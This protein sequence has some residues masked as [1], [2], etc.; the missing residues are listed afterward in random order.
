MFC[1]NKKK[2]LV[3]FIILIGIVLYSFTQITTLPTEK[4]NK[5]YIK[6]FNDVKYQLNILSE[7]N[8]KNTSKKELQKQYLLLRIYYKKWEYLAAQK[9]ANFIK[10]EINSAPLPKQEENSF[11]SNIIEPRGIQVL[12]ELIF[13]KES[14]H[15]EINEQL[16]YIKNRLNDFSPSK[17]YDRDIFEGARTTL[18]RLFTL[19]LTGYDTPGSSNGIQDA[20]NTLQVIHEDVLI[21]YPAIAARD[22]IIAH[23]LNDLFL[24]SIDYINKNN[25]F[26]KFD[27]L[28][29]LKNYINPLYKLLLQVHQLLEI[30]MPHE[31]YQQ[32]M[33]FNYQS[34]NLFANDFINKN[35]FIHVPEKFIN[36]KTKVLGQLL[37]FDPILSEKNDRSCNSCHAPEKGFTD[38]IPKSIASGKMSYL[39]RN[40]PTL[41]NSVYSERLFHDLRA[42]TFNDQMEHVLTSKNE[43]N[44]D[45]ITVLTKLNQSDEYIKLFNEVFQLQENKINA[46][47][48]QMALAVYVGSLA[49]MNSEF[50]KYI[51]GELSQLN[52]SVKNGFN[53]FMGKAVC[54]TCHFAPVFNGTV[55]PDYKESESEVLGVP[56]N[57]YVK[58][59]TIDSDEGRGKALLKDKVFFNK[60]AFKTP[61]VRNSALSF[62]YMHNGSYKTLND[63]MDF[64]NKGGGKGIG[65][66][67]EHQTL[68][69]DELKLSK[70]EM[71]DIVSFM[72]SLTDTIGLT[73][74][75][76]RLPSFGNNAE[77]NKRKIGGEY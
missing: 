12:D 77:W 59:P 32:E 68:P 6:R 34:D 74:K 9:D 10:D 16:N 27:R 38:Q 41:I 50:D 65:I 7:I 21:Y 29:F 36:E 47:Y 14:S 28:T 2:N 25:N 71:N 3:A 22:T 52:P 67:L 51:K 69:F 35:Y 4:I 13:S 11:G 60:Y 1:K 33:A 44:T 23:K 56:E 26:E 43:F 46:T 31:V 73:S 8:N 5:N 24:N 64:Y 39:T 57:P 37:F 48:L 62:P 53:L 72:E 75:P 42:R 55:P 15:E 45:M 40:S 58:K 49:G 19:S 76:K 70:K 61:T 66:V 63:V 18:V 20:K 54:G 30:E 17:I